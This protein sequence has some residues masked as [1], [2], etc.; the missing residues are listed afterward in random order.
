MVTD[1][2]VAA[3][4][5]VITKRP[6]VIRL[7]DKNSL[8][9]ITVLSDPVSFDVLVVV[10]AVAVLIATSIVVFVVTVATVFVR[11]VVVAGV[12]VEI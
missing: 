7:L 3:S 2:V 9:A 12:T 5:C 4:V 11:A 6:V 1:G 10:T 8:S